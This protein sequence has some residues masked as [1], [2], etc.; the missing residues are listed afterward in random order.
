LKYNVVTT[1]CTKI[2]LGKY[3]NTRKNGSK[4]AKFLF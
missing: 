4:H 1:N 3:G 2:S